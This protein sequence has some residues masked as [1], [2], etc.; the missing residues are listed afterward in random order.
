MIEDL[1]QNLARI[2]FLEGD[3]KDCNAIIPAS[4]VSKET[5]EI[6]E[7]LA[8]EMEAFE[9]IE[10]RTVERYYNNYLKSNGDI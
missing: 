10:N 9:T 6:T 7:P 1:A 5:K 8:I 3:L 2:K 4:N